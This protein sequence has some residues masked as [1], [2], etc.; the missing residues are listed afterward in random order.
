LGELH[1]AIS[2][3]LSRVSAYDP[4]EVIV[5]MALIA[6]VVGWAV[7]FLRGTRGAS[8]VKGAAVVIGA[9]YL[10]IQL[11]P[12]NPYRRWERIE[13]LYGNFILVALLALLVAF[14]PE[15]RRALSQL[16]RGRLFGGPPQYREE[17]LEA[18]V[19]SA[20]FLSRNKTGAIIAVERKVGLAGLMESGTT[21]DAELTAPLLNSIFVE[22]SPL[23]DM[24]VI[25][26]SGRVAAAGC[27]FPLAESEEVDASL[28]SRHRAALG[29]AKETDA[30]IIVVSEETGRISIASEGQLYVGLDG[31]ALRELLRNALAPRPQGFLARRL[32]RRSADDAEAT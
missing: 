9:V 6:L 31:D 21:L 13:W 17:Q 20:R 24:G 2:S 32:R 14:Q 15:L 7:R 25:V 18:L 28:G 10:C 19:E 5:E 22:G 29:L 12:K 8:L 4:V 30:I 1:R 3:Y 27:Q 26:Q 11:L 16:G 23:H